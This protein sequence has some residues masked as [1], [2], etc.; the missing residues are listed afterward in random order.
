MGNLKLTKENFY[1]HNSNEFS[2]GQVLDYMKDKELS[3]LHGVDGC[4]YK[5]NENA[6]CESIEC[7]FYRNEELFYDQEIGFNEKGIG[8]EVDFAVYLCL[9]CNTWVSYIE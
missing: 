5:I 2:L 1:Q 4:S 3:Y 8:E 6:R 9:K 7:E